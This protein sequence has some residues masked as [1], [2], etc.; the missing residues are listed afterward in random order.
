MLWGKSALLGSFLEDPTAASKDHLAD[1]SVSSCESNF[2]LRASQVI[3]TTPMS[4]LL[5]AFTRGETDRGVREL[6]ARKRS[7]ATK[8]EAIFSRVS[9][10]TN[11][12]NDSRHVSKPTHR[13]LRPV[14]PSRRRAARGRRC[15][16][17]WQRWG[18]PARRGGGSTCC[19]P[20]CPGRGRGSCT[21]ARPCTRT[22]AR[23]V[24]AFSACVAVICL[25]K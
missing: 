10:N 4:N 3:V 23:R 6:V 5:H 9:L 21:G 7:F 22:E 11:C 24:C 13:G 18:R 20:R 19:S 15:T 25:Y 17:R 8:H 14:A 12:Q 1:R 2:R 16:P